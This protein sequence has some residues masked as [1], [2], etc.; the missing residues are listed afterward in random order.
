M[1]SMPIV[2]RQIRDKTVSYRLAGV[3]VLVLVV[4]LGVMTLGHRKVMRFEPTIDYVPIWR[5]RSRE[6]CLRLTIRTCRNLARSLVNLFSKL[7][8]CT[9]QNEKK[10]VPLGAVLHYVLLKVPGGKLAQ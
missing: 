3:S 1:V 4:G 9:H 7:V 6:D 8:G 10:S 2:Y 5:L